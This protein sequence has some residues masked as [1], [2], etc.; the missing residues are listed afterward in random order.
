[1]NLQ[2]FLKRHGVFAAFSDNMQK[3]RDSDIEDFLKKSLPNFK[4][5]SGAFVWENTEE[6]KEFWA[7][8]DT[9]WLELLNPT[10]EIPEYDTFLKFLNGIGAE[11]NYFSNAEEQ[12]TEGA[13]LRLPYLIPPH[14]WLH[15]GFDWSNTREGAM[16][17]ALTNKAWLMLLN[18]Q[19]G[20]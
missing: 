5:I 12:L 9:I 19:H 14:A 3:Q 10:E 17:W 15:A 13:L 16:L 4:Q 20:G 2:D 1:M 18:K 6:G 8:I 7:K 11:E